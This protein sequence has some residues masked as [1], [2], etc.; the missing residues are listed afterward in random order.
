MSGAT[1]ST[2]DP[3]T[4]ILIVDDNPQYA[5]VLTRMLEGG[6][7]FTDITAV[8]DTATGLALMKASPSRFRLLFIDF[9]FPSGETGVELLRRLAS[10]G[11][12][13]GKVAFLITSE[14][15]PENLK[16]AVE[17]GALGVVAKPF[18]RAELT[19]QLDKAER[20]LQ[21]AAAESF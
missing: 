1:I 6:F 4:P 2:K 10:A 7:G 19:R 15:T 13:A 11:L 20:A 8:S 18:D 14:P 21:V 9:R 3:N 17:C 16:E 12:L 5:Q